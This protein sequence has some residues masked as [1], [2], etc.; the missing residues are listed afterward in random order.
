MQPMIKRIEI[1]TL[2]KTLTNSEKFVS[3][4][5]HFSHTTTLCT[6]KES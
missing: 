5:T 4:K 2:K 1:L 3:K 6:F